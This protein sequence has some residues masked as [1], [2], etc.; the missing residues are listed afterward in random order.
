MKFGPT[1]HAAHSAAIEMMLLTVD[2]VE[3]RLMYMS[4]IACGG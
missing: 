4:V 1:V 2:R 3:L